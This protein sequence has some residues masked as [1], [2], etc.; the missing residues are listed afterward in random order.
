M[1][2]KMFRNCWKM[3]ILLQIWKAKTDKIYPVSIVHHVWLSVTILGL[4]VSKSKIV[5][6]QH[7]IQVNV[8]RLKTLLRDLTSCYIFV[9]AAYNSTSVHRPLT[10]IEHLSSRFYDLAEMFFFDVTGS[11]N[12]AGRSLLRMWSSADTCKMAGFRH[13]G[14]MKRLHGT[15]KCR[16]SQPDIFCL[17][18][19]CG[20]QCLGLRLVRK[21]LSKQRSERGD[22]R[23]NLSHIPLRRQVHK[24]THLLDGGYESVDGQSASQSEFRTR[25]H[26]IN[27]SWCLKK[28]QPTKT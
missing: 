26:H 10:H 15:F 21:A 24:Q 9:L 6:R 3:E 11:W 14:C 18:R 4:S 1:K 27:R 5:S 22:N 20:R 19:S 23:F 25:Q 16:S 12:G 13:C 17:C 2:K 8:L 7:F 28:L